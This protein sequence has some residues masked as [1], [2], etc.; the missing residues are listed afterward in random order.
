M[1]EVILLPLLML[2]MIAGP[3]G[4]PLVLLILF[5]LIV[6]IVAVY[7]RISHRSDKE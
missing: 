6:G 2:I 3:L 1:L 4:V 5:G 7:K